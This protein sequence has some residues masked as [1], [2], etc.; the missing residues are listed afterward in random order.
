MSVNVAARQFAQPDLAERVRRALDE[1]GLPPAALKL[2]I[3][4]GTAMGDARRTEDVLRVLHALGVRFSIDDFGTGYS[5][6]SY[7]RRFPLQ[8][9]KIDRSFVEGLEHEEGSREIV[10]GIVALASALGMEVVAE[11]VESAAQVQLLRALGCGFA[12]GYFFHRPVDGP[13]LEPLL[14]APWR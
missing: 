12:Q 14:Q 13:S 1:A 10:R 2:E 5:S 6:L 11:G 3:T 7:L 9:L 8:T 4:E